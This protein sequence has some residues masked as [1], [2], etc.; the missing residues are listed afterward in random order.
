MS[1]PYPPI[2]RWIVPSE[3]LAATLKGVREC[4]QGVRE[5]GAFWLGVRQEES[6]TVAIVMPCGKGIQAGPGHWKVAPEVFGVVTRWAKPRGLSLLAV[7]HTH[8]PGVPVRLSRADREYSV[9]APGVLAVVIGE[10]GL[11]QDHTKWGWYV[12]EHTAYRNILPEELGRQIEIGSRKVE[13][14]KANADGLWSL[15]GNE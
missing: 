1:N 8:L 2:S 7:A 9:Q 4:G 11:E 10:G 3:T 15:A 14:L 5:A 6:G 13:V 12:Y